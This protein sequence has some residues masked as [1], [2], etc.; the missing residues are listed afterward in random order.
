[1]DHSRS[2]CYRNTFL[3][4]IL[5]L[6]FTN[7]VIG[8]EMGLKHKN[9]WP[10]LV[11]IAREKGLNDQQT[12]FLLAMREAENGPQGFEFGVKAARGTN[13]EEQARWA[14]ATI[15]KNDK[16]YNDYLR[17]KYVGSLR[18]TELKSGEKPLDFSTFFAHHGS[19][20]GYGWAPIE[21]VP[22]KEKMLNQNWPGN[23]NLIKQEIADEF[24]KRG[25]HN[26]YQ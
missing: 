17:G 24:T 9:E 18:T 12:M 5:L 23:V 26:D 15:I 8:G 6:F 2:R 20:T 1:M 3:I 21:N 16:R 7:L 10:A 11:R 13:L 25:V 14:A 19:P 4:I 22:A